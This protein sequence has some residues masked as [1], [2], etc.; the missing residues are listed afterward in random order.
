[1]GYKKY[2]CYV[3]TKI[4][5]YKFERGFLQEIENLKEYKTPGPP[6]LVIVKVKEG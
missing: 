1:M 3:N 5:N 4:D 6:G 2:K